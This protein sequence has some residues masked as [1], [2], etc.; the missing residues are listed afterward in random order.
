MLH[1]EK[2]KKALATFLVSLIMLAGGAGLANAATV[3]YRGV[4]VNW[5]HGR[6]WGV[7]SYSQVQTHHFTHSATANGTWSG[8][9]SPGVTAYASEYVGSGLAQ[10]Y[11][12]CK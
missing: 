1:H 7:Y 3:Y 5:D 2:T 11:W 12:D 8:W 9:K 4:A 10:A 6:T